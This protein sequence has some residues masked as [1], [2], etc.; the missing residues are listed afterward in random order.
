LTTHPAARAALQQVLNDFAQRSTGS[1]S[2]VQQAVFADF[3]LSID[4]GEIT[5][6][7]SINQGAVLASRAATVERIYAERADDGVVV[8]EGG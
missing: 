1:S 6:K 3:T 8:V 4:A 2:L 5:D 7:G